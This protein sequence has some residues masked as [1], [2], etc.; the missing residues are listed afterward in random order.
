MT[1]W[2]RLFQRRRLEHQLDS[3]LQFHLEQQVRDYVETGM[4]ESEARR[5]AGM[6]FGGIESIKEDCREVRAISFI[7]VTAQ[8]IRYA[9]RSMRKSPLFSLVVVLSLALGIG[10]NT[11]IF[12]LID[13]VTWRM[14]PVKDP[15]NSLHRAPRGRNPANRLHIPAVPR[16]SG[17]AGR[18]S[19]RLFGPARERDDRWE[20]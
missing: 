6:N 2:R 20:S 16:F 19:R 17:N 9:A 14:L 13:A 4:S 7:E 8:D 5:K 12:S 11:A 1:L 3:E 15:E 10:A 18:R